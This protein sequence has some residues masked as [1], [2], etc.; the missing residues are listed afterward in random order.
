MGRMTRRSPVVVTELY[1]TSIGGYSVAVRGRK[2]WLHRTD[3]DR[4]GDLTPTQA[5]ALAAALQ[6]CAD[7]AKRTPPRK[8]SR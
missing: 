4:D 8:A 6:A 7:K 1:A 3:P 5:L 2:V